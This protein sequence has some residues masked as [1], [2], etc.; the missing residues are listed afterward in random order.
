MKFAINFVKVVH[1]I[2][3]YFLNFARKPEKAGAVLPE[4]EK[5]I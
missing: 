3:N 2:S 4:R 1:F 5:L